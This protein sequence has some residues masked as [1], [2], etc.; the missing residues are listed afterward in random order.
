MTSQSPI[1]PQASD[2]KRHKARAK[3][4]LSSMTLLE[5]IG[6][7]SQVTGGS[8]DLSQDIKD[9][10]VGSVIN[11]VDVNTVNELQRVAIGLFPMSDIIQFHA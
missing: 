10:K 4:L 7:M 5:K 2:A 8:W 6:Q 1:S 11:E 9:G 3:E